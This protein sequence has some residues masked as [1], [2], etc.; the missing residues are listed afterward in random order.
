MNVDQSIVKTIDLS[1]QQ[2]VQCCNSASGASQCPGSGGCD[3]GFS[4]EV[5]TIRKRVN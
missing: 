2:L 4:D 3:G 1:E 5:N